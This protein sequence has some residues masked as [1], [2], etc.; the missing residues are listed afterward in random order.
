MQHSEQSLCIINE[1]SPKKKS[2]HNGEGVLQFE[3]EPE[4]APVLQMA[5]TNPKYDLGSLDFSD[6][7]W[8]DSRYDR[9]S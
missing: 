5:T 8:K 6:E 7:G 3:S 1:K 9:K 2:I 4:D